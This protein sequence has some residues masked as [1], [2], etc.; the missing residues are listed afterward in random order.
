VFKAYFQQLFNPLIL[1][2]KWLSGSDLISTNSA[3]W[4]TI[5]VDEGLWRRFKG[6]VAEHG[7]TLSGKI[8]GISVL[9]FDSTKFSF[10]KV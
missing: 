1:W 5:I 2:I 7:E 3:N 4:S 9:L 6:K 8:L 10:P